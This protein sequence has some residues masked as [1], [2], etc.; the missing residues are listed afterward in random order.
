MTISS[1]LPRSAAVE[2]ALP[3]LLK[4]L[5]SWRASAATGSRWPSR[6]RPDWQSAPIGA[7]GWSPGQFLYALCE[8][9]LEQRQIAGIVGVH[10][11]RRS[12]S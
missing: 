3:L 9:E 12:S 6:L 1:P 5:P 11:C 10:G 7:T 8:Q 4:Q 2:A